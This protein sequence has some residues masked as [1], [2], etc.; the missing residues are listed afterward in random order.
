M[1]EEVDVDVAAT[2]FACEE[3]GKIAVEADL[4]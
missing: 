3:W 2:C 1:R 4:W